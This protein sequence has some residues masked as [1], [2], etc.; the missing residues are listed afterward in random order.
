MPNKTML[1][2]IL[3]GKEHVQLERIPVPDIGP[4]DILVR[5]RT[6][7]T[8]GTDVK[9]FCRGYHARMIV[10][11]ALLNEL[12]VPTKPPTS[13]VPVTLPGIDCVDSTSKEPNS[14]PAK[15]GM[16]VA[17]AVD[18]TGPVTVSTLIV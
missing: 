17:F 15:K 5:V 16:P 8:C 4:G 6:A 14:V 9:V 13:T 12:S 3:Y 10:P 1:A 2:A 11:P 18:E 7:L